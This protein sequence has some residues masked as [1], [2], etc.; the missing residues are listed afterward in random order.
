MDLT[1]NSMMVPTK[2]YPIKSG[3]FFNP[4]RNRNPIINADNINL[5]VIVFKVGGQV[6]HRD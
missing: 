6:V 3:T 2:I 5:I 4:H 1:I